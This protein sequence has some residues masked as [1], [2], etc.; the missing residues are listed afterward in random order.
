MRILILGATGYIGGSVAAKLLSAGHEV[1]GLVRSDEKASRLHAL[2]VEPIKATLADTRAIA[3]AACRADAI[4]NAADA[5]NSLVV[6]A[7]LDAAADT[8]KR[9]IH[10]SGSSVI[11]DNAGGEANDAVFTEDTPFEP[12]PERLLRVAV[13]RLVLAAALRG[14]HSVV[15]RPTL[16]YGRGH[17]LNPHSVQIPR[18]IELAKQHGV[19]RHVGRGLNIWSH[20][21][22][23]DV[24]D[25]YLLALTNAP[26]GSLFYAENGEASW[27]VMASAVGRALGLGPETRDWPVEEAVAAWGIGAITSFGSNSRVRSF[28]ARRML[29]WN[30]TGPQLIDEIERGCYRDDFGRE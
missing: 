20:V 5:D 22:I 24:V 1:I 25:L 8:G 7:I 4:V 10:T 13:D 14:V 28:K 26:A 23:D 29:G 16:I 30:P 27:K 19:A 9:F 2:G 18:L 11:A 17:G 6:R 3:D 15:I 21:F 12:L